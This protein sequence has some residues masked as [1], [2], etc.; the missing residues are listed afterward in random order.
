MIEGM[1]APGAAGIFLAEARYIKNSA[2]LRRRA[3]AV[4]T[5][6]RRRAARR[7]VAEGLAEA[8]QASPRAWVVSGWCEGEGRDGLARVIDVM[9]EAVDRRAAARLVAAHFGGRMW[10]DRHL[11]RPAEG[12]AEGLAG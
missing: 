4:A 5:V 2:A 10:V 11:V 3:K 8:F 6:D 1:S 9:V 12:L 7:A